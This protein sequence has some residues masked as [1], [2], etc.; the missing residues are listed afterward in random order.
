MTTY[1]VSLT[2]DDVGRI[3]EAVEVAEIGLILPVLRKL[4]QQ[5]A[6]PWEMEIVED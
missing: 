2:D 1:Q 3:H 5:I 4:A 6:L